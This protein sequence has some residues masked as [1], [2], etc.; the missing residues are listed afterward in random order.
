ME[1][2]QLNHKEHFKPQ[3]NQGCKFVDSDFPSEYWNYQSWLGVFYTAD[4]ISAKE[5]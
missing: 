3:L 4:V 2:N 5:I 1:Q